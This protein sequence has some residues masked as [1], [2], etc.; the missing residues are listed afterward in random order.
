MPAQKRRDKALETHGGL[1]A[2]GTPVWVSAAV[3]EELEDTAL[4]YPGSRSPIQEIEIA[5]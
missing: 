2:A 4:R 1:R 5:S 3:K